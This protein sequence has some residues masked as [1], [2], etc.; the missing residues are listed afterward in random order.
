MIRAKTE[1]IDRKGPTYDSPSANQ[2]ASWVVMLL[3][4]QAAAMY[5]A[6]IKFADIRQKMEPTPLLFI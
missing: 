1:R 2:D 5:F 6:E 3:M 4:K